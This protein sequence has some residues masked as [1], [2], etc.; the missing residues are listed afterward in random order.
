MI[1]KNVLSQRVHC[2]VSSFME[3][4]YTI[5]GG[6]IMIRSSEVHSI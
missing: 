5:L 2:E 4:N 3:D 1:T 6:I